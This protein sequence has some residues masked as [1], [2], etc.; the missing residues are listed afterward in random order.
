MLCE[1]GLTVENEILCDHESRLSA[2]FGKDS[3][4]KRSLMNEEELK[5]KLK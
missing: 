4:P 2:E 3:R 1:I 5:M